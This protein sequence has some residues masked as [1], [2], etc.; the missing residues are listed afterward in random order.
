MSLEEELKRNLF[1]KM[2]FRNFN[3]ITRRFTSTAFP[4]AGCGEKESKINLVPH[5]VS[6]TIAAGINKQINAEQTTSII[7]RSMSYHFRSSTV[8]LLGL[9]AFYRKL[10]NEEFEHG[11]RLAEFLLL[12]NGVVSLDAIPKLINRQ[13]SVDIGCTLQQTITLEMKMSYGLSQLYRIAQSEQDVLLMDLLAGH[14]LKEQCQSLRMLQ[15]LVSKW[16]QMRAISGGLYLFDEVVHSVA[17]E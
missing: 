5:S 8:G 3:H 15:L 14:F 1:C 4:T 16:N 12:R 2:I 9:G 17:K 7:Y 11:E 13:W 6:D 10:A